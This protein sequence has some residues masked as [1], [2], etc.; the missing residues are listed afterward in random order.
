MSGSRRACGSGCT[1][2]AGAVARGR[3][4]R[5]VAGGGRRQPCAGEKGGSETGPSPVDRARNGSKHHLL[6]DATA[7]SRSPGALTGGNRHDV[8]QLIPL[9]DRVPPVRGKVGRPRR[10]PDQR[11]RRP[12]LRLRQPPPRAAPARDQTGDRPPQ[13]RA[14]LR[15]RPLPLGRRAH[16][17]LA[18]PV[19]TPARPLRTPRRDPRSV[20]RARLLPGLLPPTQELI[21]KG[22]LSVRGAGRARR[23]P[24][25]FT[26]PPPTPGMHR[27]RA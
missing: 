7:G 20:P 18:P 17:R 26:S 22:V 6:V 13:D 2:A 8:T 23:T 27:R 15:P 3:R 4:D 19:Q 14:R 5:V 10:R 11:P 24:R 21:V 1:A 9:V 16:L 12:R 25:A